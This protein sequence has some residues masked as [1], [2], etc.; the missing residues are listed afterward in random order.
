M[1]RT[2]SYACS[3]FTQLEMSNRTWIINEWICKCV[4]LGHVFCTTSPCIFNWTVESYSKVVESINTSRRLVSS[5]S[6]RWRS[7]RCTGSNFTL[8]SL[9]YSFESES[10]VWGRYMYSVV[11]C[12]T[13]F[14]TFCM[15]VYLVIRYIIYIYIYI[16]RLFERSARVF[17][18]LLCFIFILILWLFYC[19]K[20]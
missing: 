11:V 8:D 9:C 15:Y 14:I 16:R 5:Q 10:F 13:N 1:A 12:I 19:H 4:R 3:N 17:N 7:G 18:R 6:Y 2:L 20:E